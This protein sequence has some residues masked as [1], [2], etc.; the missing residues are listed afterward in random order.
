MFIEMRKTGLS[1]R[2]EDI[3]ASSLLRAWEQL[4]P[5]LSHSLEPGAACL[6]RE[7][8]APAIGLESPG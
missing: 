2:C 1:R 5:A 3:F 4:R 8:L 7:M 6:H